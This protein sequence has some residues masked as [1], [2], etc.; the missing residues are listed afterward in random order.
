MPPTSVVDPISIAAWIS[1]FKDLTV[2]AGLIF[3]IWGGAKQYWIWGYHYT[4]AIKR[5]DKLEGDVSWWQERYL[6]LADMA[7]RAVNIAESRRRRT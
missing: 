3:V 7:D 4:E 6:S 1:V 2:T 5:I